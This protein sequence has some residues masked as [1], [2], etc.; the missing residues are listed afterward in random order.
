MTSPTPAPV[1]V[2]LFALFSLAAV[3]EVFVQ[4]ADDEARVFG[5]ELASTLSLGL[6]AGERYYNDLQE[7]FSYALAK[8]CS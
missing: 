1:V 2:D 5:Q 4:V 3:L 7:D 8:I 6:A